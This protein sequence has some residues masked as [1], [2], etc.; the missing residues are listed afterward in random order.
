MISQSWTWNLT[1]GIL[2]AL[3]AAS[4]TC[5]VKS[6]SLV[7]KS[8]ILWPALL[9]LFGILVVT[10]GIVHSESPVS[11]VH[12]VVLILA[13]FQAMLVNIRQLLPWPSGGV[14]LALILT[15]IG[16]QFYPVFEQRLM[17]FLWMAVGLTKFIRERSATLE[18]GMPVWIQLLYIQAILLAAYR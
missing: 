1:E 3:I 4:V 11:V 18:G 5:E 15:G 8:L 9:V 13:G 17:G 12:G 10:Q 14:W 16:F 6:S 7:P 2:L